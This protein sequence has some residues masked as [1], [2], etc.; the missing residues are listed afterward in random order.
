VPEAGLET[1]IGGGNTICDAGVTRTLL[2]NDPKGLPAIFCRG[3]SQRA[4]VKGAFRFTWTATI[5]FDATWVLD[6]F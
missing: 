5:S 6:D 3:T 2:P 4:S 1:C